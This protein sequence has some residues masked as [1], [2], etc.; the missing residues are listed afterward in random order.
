MALSIED[1]VEQLEK[2]GI[3]AEGCLTK[4]DCLGRL[5]QYKEA[6][7]AAECPDAEATSTSAPK[8]SGEQEGS[9]RG[10]RKVDTSGVNTGALRCPRCGTRLAYAGPKST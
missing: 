4:E 10:G 1:M 9:V 7:D 6:L 8:A 2:M 5:L 3:S